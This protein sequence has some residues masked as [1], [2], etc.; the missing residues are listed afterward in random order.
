MAKTYALQAQQRDGAGKGAA[1][2]LRRNDQTPAVIYGD[3][4][5]PLP[6]TL[7]ENTINVEY[8]RGHMFTTV[9]ELKVGNDTHKV[10]ARD[11]QLHPVTDN[12]MHVDFLRVTNKTQIAVSVPVQFLN[13]DTCVGLRD[14]GGILSVIR[15]DVELRCSAMNIPDYI[16][17]DLA[18]KK[19][20]D[21]VYISDANLPEGTTPVIDDRDFPIANIAEPKKMEEVEEETAEGGEDAEAAESTE[22]AAAEEGAEAEAKEG[23]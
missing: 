21:T 16:E 23:E 4:K 12:V 14:Q 9:C 1:R 8:N 13:E 5:E 10:L 19:L 15:Y 20:H 3:N 22:S 17:V 11:V 2:A 7:D 6:I 18:E